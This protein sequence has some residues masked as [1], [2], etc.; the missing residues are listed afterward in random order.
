MA[1]TTIKPIETKTGPTEAEILQAQ[2]EIAE[3]EVIRLK[4]ENAG[5]VANNAELLRLI[6][7]NQQAQTVLSKAAASLSC[8][9]ETKEVEMLSIPEGL[10]ATEVQALKDARQ[11]EIDT[12]KS[13]H[14]EYKRYIRGEL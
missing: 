2:L 11:K 8:T 12:L 6:Q 14:E 1:E 7:E 10:T 5:L 9:I 13:K 4:A 3:A